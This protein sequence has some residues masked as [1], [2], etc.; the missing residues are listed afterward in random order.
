MCVLAELSRLDC[1]ALAKHSPS[2]VWDKL[3]TMIG[4]IDA[5]NNKV[6]S[7]LTLLV[8]I[9]DIERKIDSVKVKLD[10]LEARIE[11]SKSRIDSLEKKVDSLASEPAPSTTEDIIA[12]INV[13]TKRAFNAMIF[14]IPE[15]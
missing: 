6:E 3:N 9:D 11:S 10:C 12:E 8:K 14:K 1:S 7:L 13:R 15:F 2:D 4:K 5:L